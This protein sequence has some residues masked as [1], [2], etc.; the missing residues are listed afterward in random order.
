MQKKS[1]YFLCAYRATW[2]AVQGAGAG[3]YYCTNWA[4][5]TPTRAYVA[6]AYVYVRMCVCAGGVKHGTGCGRVA[7]AMGCMC[8]GCMCAQ[9]TRVTT[10]HMHVVSI[11]FVAEYQV[12]TFANC[13]TQLCTCC[14]TDYMHAQTVFLC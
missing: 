10:M 11:V 13:F 1:K 2:G 7:R 6:H 5:Y 12:H 14:I 3:C 9:R 8:M 4:L